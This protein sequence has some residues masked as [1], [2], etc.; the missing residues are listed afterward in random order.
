MD[1]H[2]A[3]ARTVD[4]GDAGREA[5]ATEVCSVLSQ[6]YK[7]GGDD[8]PWE[9]RHGALTLATAFASKGANCESSVSKSLRVEWY[10]MFLQIAHA[11]GRELVMP[12]TR[13]LAAKI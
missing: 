9:R 5:A 11:R 13:D 12:K 10:S 4:A 8:E 2:L 6:S 3:C 1:N 7:S